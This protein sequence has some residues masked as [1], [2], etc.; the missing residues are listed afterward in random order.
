MTLGE[1]YAATNVRTHT[2]VQEFPAD[3]GT[4]RP[5]FVYM[6]AMTI[7]MRMMMRHEPDGGADSLGTPT[8]DATCVDL[9]ASVWD[10]LDGES[11]RAVRRGIR[12][13]LADCAHCRAY[14]RFQQA[15]LRA[16]RAALS[17]HQEPSV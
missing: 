7:G 2:P 9:R 17:D 8:N 10:Y 4:S 16:V 15:F 14:V 11:P 6:A 1:W 13:H 12:A 5:G 3:A